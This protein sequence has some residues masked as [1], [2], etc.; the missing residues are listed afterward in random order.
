[1]IPRF[2]VLGSR[3]SAMISHFSLSTSRFAA[4]DIGSQSVVGVWLLASD[5]LCWSPCWSYPVAFLDETLYPNSEYR[6]TVNSTSRPQSMADC[7]YEHPESS[8]SP[9]SHLCCLLPA[10][11]CRSLLSSPCCPPCC[12]L[13]L[14]PCAG[15]VIMVEQ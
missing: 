7:R 11:C 13:Q 10:V 15:T 12:V 5:V 9:L 6:G 14:K 4:I 1:M 2:S 8:M 3:L